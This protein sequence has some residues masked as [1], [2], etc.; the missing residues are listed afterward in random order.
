MLDFTQIAFDVVQRATGERKETR[1]PYE[2]AAAE[3]GRAGGLKGGIPREKAL[4]PAR[5]KDIGQKGR[6]GPLEQESLV[7]CRSAARLRPPVI[8]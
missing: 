4:K 7:P 5:R 1:T 2:I 3:F 6:N 8:G